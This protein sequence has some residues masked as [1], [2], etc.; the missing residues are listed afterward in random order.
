MNS[1]LMKKALEKV[2]NP[3]ILVNVISRR[4]RQLNGGGGY[5]R[6]LVDVPPG[7]G[8][9]DIAMTELIEDKIGWEFEN[10]PPT[11]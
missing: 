11:E 4:V 5:G 1:E 9:A 7:M 2:G 6:P 10:P 3:H 8:A